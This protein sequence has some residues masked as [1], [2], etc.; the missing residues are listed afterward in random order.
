M[1][2]TLIAL[3][4]MAPLS[5]MAFTTDWSHDL[6]VG[7]GDTSVSFDQSGNEFS[8]SHN[9]LGISTSDTVDIGIS[10]STTLLG[11]LDATVG[12]DHQADNDNVIGLETSFGQWGATITPSLDWNVNDTDFDST[13]KVGYG[14]LGLDS[15]YS[16]DFDVDETEFSGSEAGVGYSWKLS[17]GFTLT[18]NLT[19]PYDSDWN[20]GTVVAGIS[21]NISLGSSS[22]E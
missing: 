9:G 18:P 22:S 15:Y 2:K 5:A 7:T 12:L 19:I 17:D 16:V 4:C 3:L 11:A 1:K 10:Y 6:T 8:A 14:I 21:L 20:R 13:V